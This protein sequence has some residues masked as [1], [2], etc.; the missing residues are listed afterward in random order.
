MSKIRKVKLIER[1]GPLRF[2]RIDL[3]Q[4]NTT[5]VQWKKEFGIVLP[6]R[7]ELGEQFTNLEDLRILLNRVTVRVEFRNRRPLEYTFDRGFITDLASVPK[8]FRS[9]VDNDDLRILVAALVHDYNFSTHFLDPETAKGQPVENVGFRRANKLFYGMCRNRR[10]PWVRCVLAYV[11]VNSVVGRAKY[12]KECPRRNPW[13]QK[14]AAARIL[15][16]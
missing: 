8:C 12:E 10:L 3:P 4:Y 13:T 11:A 16:R 1:E 2:E 6:T 9:F 14:T 15:P 5:R 7:K